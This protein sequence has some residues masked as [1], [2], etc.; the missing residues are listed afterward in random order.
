MCQFCDTEFVGTDGPNGGKFRKPSALAAAVGEV[1]DAVASGRHHALVVCTGGEP[2]LQLDE[3]L[4]DSLHSEGF[5]IAVETN[6]TRP[7]SAR[8]DWTA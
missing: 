1:W 7:T 6:G 5:E 8:L 2:L 4:I 3:A